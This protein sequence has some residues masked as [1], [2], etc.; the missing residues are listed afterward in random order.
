MRISITDLNDKQKS[1]MSDEDRKQFGREGM[2][3]DE[4]QA[5]FANGEENK[6]HRIVRSYLDIY[7]IYYECEPFGRRTA[8][9]AGRPDFRLCYRGRF[10]GIELK[11]VA[12]VVSREQTETLDAIRAGGGMAA[13]CYSLQD[14]IDLLRSC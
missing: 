10:I 5:R 2:T 1:L 9:K 6:L 12:G 7:R 4:A 3:G 13:V 14:V 8:V 11:T